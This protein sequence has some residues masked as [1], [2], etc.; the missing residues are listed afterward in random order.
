MKYY[1]TKGRK[2]YRNVKKKEKYKRQL[3]SLLI[4]IALTDKVTNK[5]TG[6]L[7]TISI[8][9]TVIII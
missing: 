6:A 4:F 1:I 5:V 9:R 3:V 7:G 8:G 2:K